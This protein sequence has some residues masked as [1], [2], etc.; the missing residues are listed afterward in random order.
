MSFVV[1]PVSSFFV[2]DDHI[3][4]LFSFAVRV[5]ATGS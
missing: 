2:D 3:L 4:S 1:D 5:P